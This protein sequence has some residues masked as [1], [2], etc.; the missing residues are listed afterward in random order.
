MADHEDPLHEDNDPAVHSRNSRYGL[1]LFFV[2]LL[3]YGGFVYLSAFDRAAMGAIYGGVNL[4]LWY[5]MGLIFAALAL[6]C[7]YMALCK[8]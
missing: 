5:G 2:Y 4:A 3:L 7:V 8:K 6:A 1:I